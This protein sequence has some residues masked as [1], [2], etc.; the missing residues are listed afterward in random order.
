MIR[1]F[2]RSGMFTVVSLRLSYLIINRVFSLV[3]LLGRTAS[4]KDTELLVMAPRSPC[5][6]AP[7]RTPYLDWADRA[8]FTALIRRP[9][10]ILRGH[11]LVTPRTIP[12]RHRVDPHPRR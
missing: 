12:R 8:V 7:I 2:Q 10:T 1:G 6:A 3:M 4:I 5:S 9:P 11:R